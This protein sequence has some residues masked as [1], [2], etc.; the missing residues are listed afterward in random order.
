MANRRLR[1]AAMVFAG[2]NVNVRLAELPAVS[3]AS[4][5]APS[6]AAAAAATIGCRTRPG[7]VDLN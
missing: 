2:L 1:A 5:A 3:A 7:F 4:A 6:A